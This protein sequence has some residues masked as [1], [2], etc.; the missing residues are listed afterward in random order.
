MIILLSKYLIANT[1]RDEIGRRARLKIW[2]MKIRA[3]SSPAA[4][5]NRYT[6]EPS[7]SWFFLL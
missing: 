2:W 4:G 1:P 5:T 3:G 7:E 6:N